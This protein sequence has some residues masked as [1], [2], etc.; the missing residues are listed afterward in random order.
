MSP[1]L[2]QALV[3]LTLCAF[4]L[5]PKAQSQTP[6]PDSPRTQTTDSITG[7]TGE[8]TWQQERQ[9]DLLRQQNRELANHNQELLDTVH[10]SLSFAAI[11]LLGFTALIA[12]LTTSRYT[13]D[14]ES[15]TAI[16]SSQA[17]ELRGQLSAQLGEMKTEINSGLDQASTEVT[18]S[19]EALRTELEEQLSESQQ[20]TVEASS[21]AAEGV[22]TSLARVEKKIVRKITELEIEVA[23]ARAGIDIGRPGFIAY[24]LN[25]ILELL[26]KEGFEL[27]PTE[28]P[29]LM[30]LLGRIP[31]ELEPV[32]SSIRS[33]LGK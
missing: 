25:E 13:Q 5:A 8:S 15:L 30:S 16:I 4:V 29:G 20:E 2:R 27:Y 22:K 14:K 17:T 7:P 31:P 33:A 11:F 12:W 21:E 10:N 32:V 28:L 1:R 26:K 24:P 19:R 3:L 6:C 23:K 9:I 18:K